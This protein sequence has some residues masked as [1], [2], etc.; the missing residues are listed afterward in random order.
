MEELEFNQQV[1]GTAAKGVLRG[2][3]DPHDQGYVV[4]IAVAAL[5][6]IVG[7]MVGFFLLMVE[8]ISKRRSRLGRTRQQ[9]RQNGAGDR[10]GPQRP[11]NPINDDISMISIPSRANFAFIP[12]PSAA[13][14]LGA[15]VGQ[16][17]EKLTRE[18]KVGDRVKNEWAQGWG[19]GYQ[20]GGGFLNTLAA[21]KSEISAPE[22][23][24][25]V[26]SCRRDGSSEVHKTGHQSSDLDECVERDWK[27]QVCL[28][29]KAWLRC[30]LAVEGDEQE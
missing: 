22:L 8:C 15:L 3:D 5:I 12:A 21:S 23:V 19:S 29:I 11:L 24:E 30:C 6:C 9:D 27:R 2:R 26:T 13:T 14:L 10:G 28:G 20:K 4:I 16:P 7:G 18:H 25:A 17:E 1:P